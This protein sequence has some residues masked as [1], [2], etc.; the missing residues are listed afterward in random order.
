M[1]RETETPYAS[2]EQEGAPF[3][4]P[5]Q[6]QIFSL[7]VHLHRAGHFSWKSWVA[8][9]SEE[10]TTAPLLAGESV[11]DAYYRQWAAAAE[12]M[13]LKL[14][15]TGQDEIV[16]RTEQWRQAYLHTPHGMP[17]MLSSAECA[18]EHAHHHPTLRQPVAVSPALVSRSA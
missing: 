6:A 14:Q 3:E 5:W 16:R 13:L 11:N 12:K 18:P 2:P 15:L 17:V 4:H 10:I 7:I 9:F 8:M 1:N